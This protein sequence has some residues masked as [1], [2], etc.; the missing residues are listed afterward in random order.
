MKGM[1]MGTV[2]IGHGDI[3][4]GAVIVRRRGNRLR[5]RRGG[6][7]HQRHLILIATRPQFRR[8]GG[9]SHIYQNGV[10]EPAHDDALGVDRRSVPGARLLVCLPWPGVHATDPRTCELASLP[11]GRAM[12]RFGPRRELCCRRCDHE[13]R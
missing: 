4:G 7:E 3:G 12:S 5:L 2:V 9:C 10:G 1:G 13:R 11:Q 6:A 8:S